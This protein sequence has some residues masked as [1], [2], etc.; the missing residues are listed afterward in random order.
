MG[1][2]TEEWVRAKAHRLYVEAEA[3]MD[4]EPGH[5]ALLVIDMTD[6]FV[7]PHW[8]PYWVPAATR[9]VP[10]IK[11]VID[12]FRQAGWPVIYLAY[13]LGQRGLN[14]PVTDRLVPTT[15]DTGPFAEFLWKTVSIF[16]DIAPG[17]SDLV[18]LKHCY[19][20]FQGTEL[21]FVLRSLDVSTVVTAREAYWRGFKVIFGSDITATDDDDMHEAELRTLRRGFAR[22]MASPQIIERLAEAG[23]PAAEPGR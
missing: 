7:K 18:V 19:S 2:F 10:R 9:A 22:I 15:L 16:A 1:E 20:G 23:P 6:E 3:Q 8:S 11:A 17:D 21:E 13:Q 4:I 12:A 14:F 5:T